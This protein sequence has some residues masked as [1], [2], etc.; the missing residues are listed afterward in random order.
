MSVCLI[1]PHLFKI[2][3][4]FFF[5][6][7]HCFFFFSFFIQIPMSITSEGKKCDFKGSQCV[8]ACKM[9]FGNRK[10]FVLSSSKSEIKVVACILT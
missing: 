8:H 3:S 5:F 2:L 10:N 6:R 4:F 7:S 9:I 1:I